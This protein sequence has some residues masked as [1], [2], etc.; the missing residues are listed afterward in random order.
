ML[1]DG[2]GAC[3][4]GGVALYSRKGGE[5]FI[6]GGLAHYE[7]HNGGTPSI[8]G[9]EVLYCREGVDPSMEKGRPSIQE[10]GGILLLREEDSSFK[11]KE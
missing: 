2:R 6:K 9:V 7:R 5:P 1:T 10:K 3:L 11:E 4:K 8:E